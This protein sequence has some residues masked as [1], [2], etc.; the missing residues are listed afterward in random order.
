MAARQPV[1]VDLFHRRLAVADLPDRE[2][3][4]QPRAM[5]LLECDLDP[6]WPTNRRLPRDTWARRLLGRH[7]RKIPFHSVRHL[8]LR[9]AVAPGACD[10]DFHRAV[11][12]VEPPRLLGPD[13]GA[14]LGWCTATDRRPDVGRH[15][16][17]SLCFPG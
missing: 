11:L 6:S 4:H 15:L 1:R 17:P 8:S 13:A 5:G 2:G 3:G 14:V 12:S 9:S 16:L 10:T 7:S